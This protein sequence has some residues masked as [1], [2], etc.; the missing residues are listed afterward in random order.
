MQI[1]VAA[2]GNSM[3]V[4]SKAKNRVAIWFSN[5]TS[6]PVSRENYNLKKIH[7]PQPS[8][9]HYLQLSR[10]GNKVSINRWM[11]KEYMVHIYNGILLSHK[12]NDIMPS[13]AT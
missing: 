4:P 8:Q 6:G 13:A 11:D 2:V 7:A 5:P 12:K 10:H 3:E 9:Q 1:G